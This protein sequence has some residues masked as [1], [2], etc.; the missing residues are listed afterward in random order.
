M[1]KRVITNRLYVV[2]LLVVA[3]TVP[4]YCLAAISKPVTM[5]ELSLYNGDYRQRILEEGAKKEGKLTFYTSGSFETIVSPIL[6]AFKKKYPFIK[7]DMWRGTSP[8]VASRAM[9]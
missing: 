7:V 8:E 6:E 4:G 9:E 1:E 2:V 5:V 3:V